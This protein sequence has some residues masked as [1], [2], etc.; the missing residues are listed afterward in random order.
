V[1]KECY[2]IN[3]EELHR[4]KEGLLFV[5]GREGDVYLSAVIIL[6][7]TTSTVLAWNY[8]TMYPEHDSA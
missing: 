1:S 2:N 6:T 4:E 3:K 5:R 7:K 8:E